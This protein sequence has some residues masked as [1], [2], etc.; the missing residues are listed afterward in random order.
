MAGVQ[1]ACERLLPSSL[2]RLARELAKGMRADYG[3]VLPSAV[4]CFED[5]FEACG[6]F[7]G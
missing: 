1:G 4:A 5:D 7:H 3:T 2:A 6:L